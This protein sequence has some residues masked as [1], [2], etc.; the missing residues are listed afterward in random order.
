MFSQAMYMIPGVVIGFV[1]D[2]RLKSR[3]SPDRFLVLA[4]I[5][6]SVGGVFTLVRS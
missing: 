2:I 1:I 4:V 6:V 5:L 3:V